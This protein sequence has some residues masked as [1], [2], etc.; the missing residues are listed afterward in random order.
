MGQRFSISSDSPDSSN[1]GSELLGGDYV[2][3]KP[4]EDYNTP[5]KINPKELHFPFELKKKS[6][7]T[8]QLSNDSD[9]YVA[10]KIRASNRKNYSISPNHIGVVLPSS[11]CVITVTMRGKKEAPLDMQY[12]DKIIIRS[13]VAKDETIVKNIT[14]E[15]FYKDSGYEVKECR[16]KIVYVAPPQ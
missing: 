1:C 16:L 4:Q 6:S 7:C 15:M 5:L 9:D 10:F 11:T 2:K 14:S 12:K 8:L 3:L 13:I